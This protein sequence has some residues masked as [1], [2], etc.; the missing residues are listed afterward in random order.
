MHRTHSSESLGHTAAPAIMTTLAGQ[1]QGKGQGGGTP[2]VM[3]RSASGS[4]LGP[5]GAALPV[6]A[7]IHVHDSRGPP[8]LLDHAFLDKLCFSGE[9]GK[10]L[11]PENQGISSC[12]FIPWS[13]C[14]TVLDVPAAICGHA[15]QPQLVDCLRNC[16]NQPAE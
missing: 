3:H 2:P 15:V 14:A 10:A 9:A 8:R 1:Q 7:S 6:P 12:H 11:G 5:A 4:H 13:P 16:S